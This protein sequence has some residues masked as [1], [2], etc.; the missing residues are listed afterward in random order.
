MQRWLQRAAHLTSGK[1][2]ES[3]VY[4]KRGRGNRVQ[5]KC[6]TEGHRTGLEHLLCHCRRP[7][8]GALWDVGPS[9]GRVGDPDR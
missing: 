4:D 7:E 2:R 3:Y 6:R 8:E 9:P 5:F 1:G